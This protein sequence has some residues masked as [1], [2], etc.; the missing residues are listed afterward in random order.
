MCGHGAGPPR[1]RRPRRNLGHD[2]LHDLDDVGLLDER[3]L[4]VELGELRLAEAAQVLVAEVVWGG[5]RPPWSRRQRRADVERYFQIARCF[6]DEDL[7]GYRQPEFTQLDFEMSFVEEDDVI[8]HDGAVMSAV[9]ALVDG[10]EVPPAPWPHLTYAEAMLKYGN[11]KP[12]PRFGLE[13]HDVG[14]AAAG[15][16]VQGLQV[17]AGRGG[18][19][20]AI[21]AGAREM[22][23]SELDGLNDIVKIFGAKAAAP[24]LVGRR[25]RL[26][27]QP[28]EVLHRGADRR[29]RRRAG[30]ERRRPAA[31]RRRRGAHGRRS[32]RRPA[33]GAGRSASGWSPRA[34]TTSLWIIEFPM[35]EPTGDDGSPGP[36][37]TTLHGADED[38]LQR[39]GRA[40][41]A[42]LRPGAGR[43]RDRRRLDP[44]P[45]ARPCRRSSSRSSAWTEEEAERASG[46]CWTP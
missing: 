24:I 10:F 42:R 38:R 22:S 17:R 4:E 41:L 16:G 21:N 44:H 33:A 7:R 23:R 31:V 20:R 26:A 8:A 1:S 19:I 29:G 3:H 43:R 35:F 45:R 30:R 5:S 40:R 9:F 32:A 2:R 6:R 46:S 12:D 27:R 25:G 37:S 18:V 13:I 11:D 14:D 36:R 34:A 28:G 15:L 39:P